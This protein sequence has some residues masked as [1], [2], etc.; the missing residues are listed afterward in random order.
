MEPRNAKQANAGNHVVVTIE[1]TPEDAKRLEDAFAAGKLAQIGVIDIQRVDEISE[2]RWA[3]AED[4]NNT[5][6]KNA[7]EEGGQALK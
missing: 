6:A 4:E 2:K 5:I 1:V 7:T 3:S